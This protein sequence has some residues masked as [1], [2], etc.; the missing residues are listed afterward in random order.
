M[1][2]LS[3]MRMVADST[4]VLDQQT[5]HDTKIDE[6]LD[7][8]SDIL[9]SGQEKVVIFSQWERM[10]R[11]MAGELRKR[12]IDHRFLHGGVPSA[13]RGKLIEDFLTQPGCRV[14]LS[15]DAGGTGLNLQAASV[16]INFDLPWNP[17]VL[18]QRIAR[19]YRLG[20][21][22]QVQVINMV[23]V[24]T[25][26]ENMLGTIAFKTGL[27]EGV[28]D[29]GDDAIVLSDRK[30]DRIARL[31]EDEVLGHDSKPAGT[32][33]D[34]LQDDILDDYEDFF[35]DD[36]RDEYEYFY[37]D[38]VY[39]DNDDDDLEE[40]EEEPAPLPAATPQ[41][42]KTESPAGAEEIIA[43]GTEFLSGLAELLATPETRKKLVDSLVREDPATGHTT[44]NIP[45]PDKQTVSHILDHLS[46]LLPTPNK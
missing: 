3:M 39:Y 11:I 17:A 21:S 26:E 45:V 6:A 27:F 41:P 15:T 19:V 44:I 32:A 4:F 43:K 46:T 10:Q 29:G 38:D 16:V 37:D 23:S 9:E 22:R 28:L 5:R 25:I 8:V 2:M 40:A 35:A 13:K 36:D 24:G 12:G 34:K 30:F 31:V 14:F 33:D 7:I 1:N 20:Q 18:E 42:E